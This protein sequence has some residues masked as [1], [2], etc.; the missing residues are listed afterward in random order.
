MK[1]LLVC[2]VCL[3]ILASIL[4]IRD[5]QSSREGYRP[6][7]GGPSSVQPGSRSTRSQPSRSQPSSRPNRSQ[8]SKGIA[9]RDSVVRSK[10]GSSQN[11][12]KIINKNTVKTGGRHN[13]DEG[14]NYPGYYGYRYPYGY[15]GWYAS[16]YPSS[17]YP[18]WYYPS[19]YGFDD[20]M[21]MSGYI[22]GGNRSY[23]YGGGF[24]MNAPMDPYSVCYSPIYAK[25]AFGP[26]VDVAGKQQWI[27][28]ANKIGG[29]DSISLRK[30]SVTNDHAILGY[31]GTCSE[32]MQNPPPRSYETYPLG[33]IYY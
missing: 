32:S 8:P 22:R 5:F 25:Q 17:Y 15:G 11:N 21:D 7:I 26:Y 9:K 31:M 18:T 4:V 27:D 1:A 23:P 10:K 20:G 16:T 33:G 13:V 28:M 19:S 29:V 12:I 3:L 24:G 2:S 6:G 30:D 14:Y